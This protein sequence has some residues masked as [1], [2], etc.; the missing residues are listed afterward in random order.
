MPPQKSFLC[1]FYATIVLYTPFDRCVRIDLPIPMP[2]KDSISVEEPAYLVE[3]I[4][5]IDDDEMF[6]LIPRFPLESDTR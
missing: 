6:H 1:S 3:N 4:P 2:T 5:Q